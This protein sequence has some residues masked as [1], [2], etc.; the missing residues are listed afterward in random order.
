MSRKRNIAEN[1]KARRSF[2]LMERLEAG[3]SLR[4][5]EVKSLRAGRADI[6][7]AYVRF[8]GGEAWLVDAHIP[9][10]AQAGPHNNHTPRRERKLLLSSTELR[11]WTRKVQER[12]LTVVAL[13]LYFKGPWVKVEIGLGRGRKRHDKRQAL[14]E[15]TDSRDMARAMRRG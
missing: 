9:Q 7:E 1:R 8:Q 10:Y 15:R 3:L 2:E 14:K 11:K 6:S 12:G 4:G 5:S 13:K